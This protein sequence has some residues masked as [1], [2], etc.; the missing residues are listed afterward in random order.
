MS[1]SPWTVA[2]RRSL[3]RAFQ[4]GGLAASYA[5]LPQ[6]TAFGIEQMV[7]KLGLVSAR[8]WADE[9]VALLV[10]HWDVRNPG[11]AASVLPGRS[12]RALEDKVRSLRC[13][14]RNLCPLATPIADLMRERP[15]FWM[16]DR[17]ATRP[18]T[19]KEEALLRAAWARDGIRAARL[20]LPKRSVRALAAKALDLALH[21][22]N[23]AAA[24]DRIDRE[25]LTGLYPKLG[26]FGAATR[27][28]WRTP[29]AIR[30]KAHEMGLRAGPSMRAAPSS[31]EQAT[32]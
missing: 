27:L 5:A 15:S 3:R 26:A 20:A 4:R 22:P 17:A 10:R 18:W 19:S 9:D 28:T 25:M 7:R 6:R 32:A 29:G 1:R 23:A 30:H 31:Q 16:R 24:W 13:E 2:E 8:R 11:I 14:Y 21:S 12:P